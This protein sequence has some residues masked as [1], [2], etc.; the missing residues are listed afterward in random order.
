MA[1]IKVERKGRSIWPWVVGLLVL[2]LL[3]W[4]LTLLVGRNG[5]QDVEGDPVAGVIVGDRLRSD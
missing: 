2:A 1:D 5:P 4:A 3:V